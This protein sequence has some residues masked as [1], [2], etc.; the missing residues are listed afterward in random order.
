MLLHFVLAGAAPLAGG[1]MAYEWLKPPRT[2]LSWALSGYL[3]AVTLGVA[4]FL[5]RDAL[6]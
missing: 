2:S 3:V 6:K 5:V 4:V 1:F